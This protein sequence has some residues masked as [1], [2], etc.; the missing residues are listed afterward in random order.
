MKAKRSIW[1]LFGQSAAIAWMLVFPRASHSQ[2]PKLRRPYA[3]QNQPVVS[4]YLNL[5]RDGRRSA[6]FNYFTLV[7]P[8]LQF[9]A[10][11]RQQASEIRELNQEI[12]SS[13]VAATGHSSH[14]LNY[15][16]YFPQFGRGQGSGGSVRGG[17]IVR[18]TETRASV[19]LTAP[20]Q[21]R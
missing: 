14:F 17:G 21:R 11:L 15:S 13:P 19:S 6:A 5:A 1:F 8:E 18:T 12:Q 20:S 9:R 10:A 3:P 7:R 16:H 4:P 2:E